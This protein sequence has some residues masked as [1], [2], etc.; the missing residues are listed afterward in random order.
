[1][2]TPKIFS[3]FLLPLL[4]LTA[5][6]TPQTGAISSTQAEYD[7][8]ALIL[9]GDVLLNH[10][11]GKM[12]AELASLQRQETGKEFPFSFIHLENQVHLF[13]KENAELSCST[14]D[15][16]F[17]SQK[18]KL[19]SQKN[20]K[21]SYTDL[22]RQ[23]APFQILGKEADLVFIKENE[24]P[25]I[26]SILLHD[27]VSIHY[28][29][30]FLL[31][32]G[33]A[34][35][36]KKETRTANGPAA[37]HAGSIVASPKNEGEKCLIL[38]QED[39]VE[40]KLIRLDLIQSQL[41]L[42]EPTG[43]LSSSLIPH[44]EQSRLQFSS[45]NLIWDHLNNTLQ[46]LGEISIDDSLL[47]HFDAKERL[48]LSQK[49]ELGK[50]VLTALYTK[51][52]ARFRYLDRIHNEPQLLVSYGTIHFQR[53]KMNAL[54]TSPQTANGSVQL[55]DQLYYEE[56]R[57]SAF[58]NN[59]SLDFVLNGNQLQPSSLTLTGAI[60]FFSRDPSQPKRC[61]LADRVVYSPATRTFI[62]SANPGKKVLFWD[63]G[64]SLS[65]CAQEI[66][67][68]KDPDSGADAI[69]GVGNITFSFTS[70]ESQLLHQLFPFYKNKP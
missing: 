18:G 52:D 48:S 10:S 50:T 36:T 29:G 66:H 13:L 12:K 15:L 70:E 6:E 33:Q 63:E 5:N 19:F 58:A 27:D 2:M 16:D 37:P 49:K 23:N 28:A 57:I 14:A 3:L 46:L 42:S 7:G 55:E 34:L 38:H 32:A 21:V 68:T 64:Q 61:A 22:L 69:Q 59:A 4:L 11:L 1:M 43:V 35:Y 47:G 62:L 26:E 44:P 60:R 20:S 9:K 17:N 8:N 31:T 25:S 24:N 56:A 54:L 40:A 30:E 39:R 51:G 53:D 41:L 45:Q 67:I 65:M